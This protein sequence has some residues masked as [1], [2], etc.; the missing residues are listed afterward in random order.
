MGSEQS[1]DTLLYHEKDDTFSVDLRASES[2]RFLFVASESKTTRFNF[3]F[4]VSKP[5]DGLKILTPRIDGID[6]TA[7]H[8]GDHFFITRRS[9]ELFNSEV[10]ACPLDNVTDTTVLLPHRER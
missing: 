9:N 3:Y 1:N 2:K 10:V 4:D 6:T 7:S 8:R 5:E